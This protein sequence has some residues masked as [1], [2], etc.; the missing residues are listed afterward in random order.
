MKK[1]ILVIGDSCTDVFVY[2]EATRL[3]PDFPIPVLNIIHQKNNPGMAKNV[4]A[5][6]QTHMPCEIYTNQNWQEITKTRYVHENTNHLFF[7]VDSTTELDKINLHHVQFDYD[8]IAIS[9]YNKGF[10]SENDIE[11]ICSKHQ[12]VFVDTKKILGPWI[13]GAKFIKINDQEYKKS[14]H[15]ITPSLQDKIIHTMGGNGCEFQNKIYK[16]KKADVKDASGAGDSFLAALVIKYHQSKDIY[17]SIKYANKCAAEVVKHRGVTLIT[18][19]D[20]DE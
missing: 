12:N 17:Q 3:A 11:Y 18:K 20:V 2:C 1:N 4:Q 19:E 15:N 5:N 14:L 8:I 9:D 7:R 10:L 6:I 13:N 16:V